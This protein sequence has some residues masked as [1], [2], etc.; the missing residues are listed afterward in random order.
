MK[1]TPIFMERIW[2]GERIKKFYR[3]VCSGD[4]IGESWDVSSLGEADS[5]I[6]NGF[7]AE[8]TLSEALEIYMEELVG[9]NVYSKYG[10]H[11]PVLLKLLDAKEKL[12]IQVHPDDALA[13]EVHGENGKAELWYVMEADE[14]AHVV[15]GF[16]RRVSEDEF[17][18]LV[19]VGGLDEVLKKIPVKKGDVL[20]IPAGCV[21][22]ICA[23]VLI[24]E[25]QQASD[26]TYRAY[27]YNRRDKDGNKRELHL[28]L[29]LRAIKYDNW[30]HEKIRYVLKEGEVS[31]LID[32]EHFS[33]NIMQIGKEKEYNLQDVESFVLLTCVEGHVTVKWDD[34]YLTLADGETLFVPATMERLVLVPTVET[35]L[36]ETYLA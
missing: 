15:V 36:L 21:H 16:E 23:G 6:E 26:I 29:A 5:I 10:N 27:D 3:H 22:A 11:F 13:E 31:K 20:M 14:G 18:D 35:R 4:Q 33:V 8:S 34:D 12:S 19:E 1:F 32:T 30:N 25:I 2:G 7:L 24:C 28:D 9:E 17:S